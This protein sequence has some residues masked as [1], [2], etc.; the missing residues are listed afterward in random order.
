MSSIE[1]LEAHRSRVFATASTHLVQCTNDVPVN[2]DV[3][4]VKHYHGR[5]A[6]YELLTTDTAAAT[7]FYHDVVGWGT[8]DASTSQLSYIQFTAGEIAVGGLME[9][10]QEGRKMGATPRWVG[11]VG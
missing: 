6:W 3:D 4:M 7:A 8:Q 5:F 2:R 10:P 9:L 11:Y 1:S